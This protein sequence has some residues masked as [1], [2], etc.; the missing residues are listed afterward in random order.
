M[1]RDNTLDQ[2]ANASPENHWGKNSQ[3]ENH[4]AV[5]ETQNNICSF[6]HPKSTGEKTPAKS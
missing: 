1:A 4:S 3:C 6:C 5:L 2:L